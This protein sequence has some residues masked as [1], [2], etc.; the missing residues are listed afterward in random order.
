[1]RAAIYCGPRC[2]ELAERPD[3]VVAAPTDA[4]VRLT[5]AQRHAGKAG[6][7]LGGFLRGRLYV[8]S[9]KGR[10]AAWYGAIQVRHEDRIRAGGSRKTSRSW[11]VTTTST[12]H[13]ML[14]TETNTADTHLGRAGLHLES[15]TNL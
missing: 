14:L 7:D 15:R 5:P 2:I 1:M 11:M 10:T 13:S 4:V 3:P 9:W 8:R 12:T 6:D